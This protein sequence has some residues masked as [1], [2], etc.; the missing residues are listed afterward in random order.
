MNVNATTTKSYGLGYA[1]ALVWGFTGLSVIF[2]GAHAVLQ[3]G[4]E[5]GA[6]R[7][8]SAFMAVIA[9]VALLLATHLVI[10][11]IR[12][13]STRRLWLSMLRGFCAV[14]AT[15][16]G[17]F[18]FILSFAALSDLA[19]RLHVPAG[20]AWM[21]P[22][23]VDA[24][25]V[26]AT[27][28]VV[29]AEAEMNLDRADAESTPESTESAALESAEST[30]RDHA[31]TPVSTGPVST[32]SIAGSPPV[33]TVSSGGHN[34]VDTEVDSLVDQRES[35]ESTGG[36]ARVHDDESTGHDEPE[37]AESTAS[38]SI[39]ST[40]YTGGS[41][42]DTAT[43]A[44][45]ESTLD[46]D[47]D[48]VDRGMDAAPESTPEAVTERPALRVVTAP[49]GSLA[50]RVVE[51]LGGDV[52]ADKVAEA[53]RLRSEGTS[54]RGIADELGIG[55]HSTVRKW[56]KAAEEMQEVVTA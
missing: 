50:E 10:G 31:Y 22:A 7:V 17:L 15:A 44:S 11:L 14:M 52:D 16:I 48:T 47:M 12:V 27:L 5:S 8:L 21:V 6:V 41:M 43:P 1:W 4:A 19:V 35:T 28:S 46:L 13:W 32:A 37:S 9:P 56:V 29:V 40:V 24:L 2:N 55:S 38:E 33:S 20:Q 39:E 54:F 26:I 53:L 34:P 42:V 3:S 23:V 49:A 30:G 51:T 45:T 36:H 18:A 25:I